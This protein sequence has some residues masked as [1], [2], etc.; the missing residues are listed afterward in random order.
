[1]TQRVAVIGA[2]PSGLAQLR[3]F[4]SAAAKGDAIPEVVCFEKQ[5]NWGGLWNYTWRTG[6]D[7]YGEPVHGSMYRYLWSNGPK[8]GLEFADY[9]FEEHFGKQIASYPP[10]AVM[11]DYIEG[12][13]NKAEVRDW[14]RFSSVVRN[15]V[16]DAEGDNFTVT[17]HDQVNDRVYSEVFDWVVV[18]SGHFSTPNMPE[19]PGF[20]R[21]NGRIVHAH[22]FRDARAFKGQDVLL[23]GTSYSAEDIG[24]QCW[25]YGC[26]SITVS[27]RTAPMG[28]DWPENWREVPILSH[29][30]EDTAHFSDGTSKRVDAII[31]CTGYKHYFPFLPDDLR[32]KTKNRLAAADLYRGV[33]Y[34]HNPKLLYLGM[35]DQWFTFN[36]FDAQ[37]WYARDII[38]DRIAIPADKQ[39]LMADVAEREARE[40]AGTDNKYAIYYQGDYVKELIALTDYPDFDVDGACEAFLEWKHHKAENIMGFRDNSYRSVIT[41]TMA[42]KH[43]TPWKDALDD[44]MEAYL[45][46]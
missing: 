2:G 20:E 3:A 13:V 28:F 37:A 27:Y 45:Q 6:V 31:L 10:R 42:P 26:K 23:I 9:S 25:K 36:M 19:Y 14:I 5:S 34:V 46:N 30:T 33:V 15:V 17:V 16:Y 29:V 41:G 12:R 39:E 18:A 21:F 22:D 7:E 40:D 35:Q 11:F 24:S 4:Q 8:E 32:L 43:H 38:M 1:M 44:S